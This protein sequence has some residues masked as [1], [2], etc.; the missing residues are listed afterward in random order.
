[1]DEQDRKTCTCERLRVGSG[2]KV[3]D[4]SVRELLLLR[5]CDRIQVSP[6]Q[7]V[8]FPVCGRGRGSMNMAW[9]PITMA[10]VAFGYMYRIV[11]I[12]SPPPL[13]LEVLV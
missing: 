4:V 12:I 6:A 1:M 3:A 10:M 11:C 2:L 5:L 8:P 7:L 13:Q 9:Q